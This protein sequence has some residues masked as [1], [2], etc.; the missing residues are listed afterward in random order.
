MTLLPDP[1]WPVAVIAVIVAGDAAMTFRP[2]TFIAA[3]LDGVGLPRD[4]WWV[5]AVVKV[6]AVAGLIAGFWIPGVGL[7]AMAGLVVYFL[8]AA[9]AHL[10]AGYTGRDFWLNCLGMLALTVLV[11]IWC[12]LV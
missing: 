8:T 10:R 2:P 11:L 4:W 12:F 6:T 1:W 5:L 7:A 3:C 9:G